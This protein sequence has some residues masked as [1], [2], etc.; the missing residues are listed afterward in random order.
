MHDRGQRKN[1]LAFSKKDSSMG[2]VVSPRD[3]A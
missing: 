2:E 1:F 3:L